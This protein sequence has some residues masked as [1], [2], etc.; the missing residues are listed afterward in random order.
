MSDY[1]PV[2]T[3]CTRIEDFHRCPRRRWWQFEYLNQHRVEKDTGGV[4]SNGISMFLLTGIGVHAA[5]EHLGKLAIGKPP[6]WRLQ[7]EEIREAAR[8]AREV[9]F[10]ELQTRYLLIGPKATDTAVEWTKQ[11]QV[12]LVEGMVW[13]LGVYL[14]PSFTA[15]FEILEAEEDAIEEV[16]MNV[17]LAYKPD[18][19]MMD[20]M[21]GEFHTLSLK[22]AGAVDWYTDYNF[23]RDLQGVTE[24]WCA[25]KRLIR[26]GKISQPIAGAQMLHLI[27][28]Q[29]R[30]EKLYQDG[31]KVTASPLIR[32]WKLP[33]PMKDEDQWAWDSKV[34]KFKRGGEAYEGR[35][36]DA[37]KATSVWDPKD[38]YP[39]GVEGWVKALARGVIQPIERDPFQGCWYMPQAQ[40]GRSPSLI[41]RRLLQLSVQEREIA[42]NSRRINYY[43]LSGV[44]IESE[45]VQTALDVAFPMYT[46][47]CEAMGGTCEYDS[48]C[49]GSEGQGVLED[50]LQREFQP[51]RPHHKRLEGFGVG[52]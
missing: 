17:H 26:A 36:G 52:A 14:L 39:G 13:M 24:P 18:A 44:S 49:F 31:R 33:G 40:M 11:E 22:T 19:V 16:T 32:G 41:E 42:E 38:G 9:F 35:L 48:L 43:L 8:I 27:K 29:R 1:F 30:E 12:N 20:R 7:D 45:R 2:I 28:G 37:W 5:M 47:G 34:E 25:S 10:E 4:V 51:R 15:R 3:D 50:K 46:K 21:S 6:D 23:E